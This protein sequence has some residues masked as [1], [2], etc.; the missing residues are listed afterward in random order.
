MRG[1]KNLPGGWIMI[2]VDALLEFKTL[3]DGKEPLPLTL[4]TKMQET[5][6]DFHKHGFVY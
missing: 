6:E 2:V 3:Y 1:M 5:L 4:F